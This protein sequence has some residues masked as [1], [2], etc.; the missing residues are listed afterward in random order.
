MPNI[1]R[2]FQRFGNNFISI[3]IVKTGK[4]CGKTLRNPVV[5][6]KVAMQVATHFANR[7][8]LFAGIKM[9]ERFLLD[10]VDSKS[11]DFIVNKSYKFAF[12]IASN[13]T[14]TGLP[15]F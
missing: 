15:W 6:A 11:C 12:F 1:L 14:N 2:C 8:N 10:G 7:K 13:F 5:L 9:I 3:D 4:F